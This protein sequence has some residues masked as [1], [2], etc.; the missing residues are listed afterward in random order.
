MS[1]VRR[2]ISM[3]EWPCYKRLSIGVLAFAFRL[4]MVYPALIR[5]VG[6][7]FRLLFVPRGGL[8]E[9]GLRPEEHVRNYYERHL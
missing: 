3:A 8:E 7:T 5:A 4:Q 1:P 9:T 2:C 6:A